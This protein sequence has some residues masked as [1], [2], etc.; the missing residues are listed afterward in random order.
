VPLQARPFLA[1]AGV[2]EPDRA[3]C[4]PSPR[5]DVFPVGGKGDRQ[6]QSLC[7]ANC[8]APCG[9]HVQRRSTFR[10]PRRP[11]CRP[12]KRSKHRDGAA[13]TE[14]HSTQ[15]GNRS[16]RQRVAVEVGGAG[17]SLCVWLRSGRQSARRCLR[18]E[19]TA[20]KE[21]GRCSRVAHVSSRVRAASLLIGCAIEGLVEGLITNKL[22]ARRPHSWHRDK[23]GSRNSRSPP[24]SRAVAQAQAGQCKWPP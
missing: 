24:A 14:A 12:G 5:G 18:S 11:S 6:I 22:H 13:V 16:G 7:P 2:P 17:L 9:G 10:P 15:A 8:A 23:G 19:T 20:R 4:R 3:A 21:D 1:G